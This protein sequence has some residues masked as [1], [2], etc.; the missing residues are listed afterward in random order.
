MLRHTWSLAL[1]AT[2]F[3]VSPSHAKVKYDLNKAGQAATINTRVIDESLLDV[4]YKVS[5]AQRP[6]LSRGRVLS[7]LIE[8]QLLGQYALKR[9]GRSALVEDNKVSF[10]PKVYEEQEFRA[11][12]QIAF[13][14]PL[15]DARKKFGGNL[16]QTLSNESPIKPTEWDTY[17]PSNKTIQAEFKL[18]TTGEEA[19]SKRILVNYKFDTTHQG[20]ISLLE[21]YNAQNVQGR[22]SIHN[23]DAEFVR[24]QARELVVNHF[25]DYWLTTAS[26]LSQAQITA[27]KEAIQDKNYHDAFASLIG[28][29]ADIHDDVQYIKDLAKKVTSQEIKHYYQHHKNEFKRI[30][31]VKAQHITLADEKTANLVADALKKGGDFTKL[32]QQY[33]MAMDKAN[34]G[35]LG[36]IVH[37]NK[38]PS[39]L[40]TLAFVQAPNVPSRPVRTPTGQWEIL[41]VT[42]KE[43]GF[44]APDSDSVRYV[45]SQIIARQKV[46]KEYQQIRTKLIKDADIHIAPRYKS[47]TDNLERDVVIDKPSDEDHHHH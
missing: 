17:L 46:I 37:D 27:I 41:L 45:A 43:E 33:S 8:N 31:R 12:M 38:N 28:I 29:A 2:L 30:E 15:A 22:T 25:L 4:M 42:A 5:T 32:A 3:S 47:Q 16:D 11:V 10:K 14:K 39:W 26:G 18:S 13:A 20:S 7:A 6:D 23:R 21:V 35:H 9:F 44:Q 24:Q 1:I 40:N 36:W 34:G 19:A